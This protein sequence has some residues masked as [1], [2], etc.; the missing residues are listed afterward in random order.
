MTEA[1][2]ATIAEVVKQVADAMSQAMKQYGPDAVDL[3]LMAYRVE[4]AQQLLHGA[5]F[6]ISLALLAYV[7]KRV[8]VWSGSKLD[9]SYNDEPII[10]G[11]AL[12]AIVSV[13]AGIV[14]AAHALAR[15]LD[16]SA[17][18]AAFGWPELRIAMKALEAAGLL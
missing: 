2:Q 9:G 10:V 15:L 4:S 3:A 11:R 16:A 7:F 18:L 12:G 17:W 8:W 5:A 13:I 6:C 14:L 1:T